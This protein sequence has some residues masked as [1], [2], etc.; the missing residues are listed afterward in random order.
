MI[1]RAETPVD[2]DAAHAVERLAFGSPLE[3][4]IVRAVRG[5]K[6][7]FGFV[8]EDEKGAV[9]GHVQC[10]RVWVG[11][12]QVTALGPIGVLPDRQGR[13]IGRSLVEAAVAEASAGG[14]L[15]VVLLGD[16]ALYSRFGFRPAAE[17]GLQNPFTGITEDGFT[18][19]EEDFMLLPLD[20]RVES[21]HGDVRWHPAFGQ[22]G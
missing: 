12:A 8:A 22:A 11:E 5:E 1:I 19:A 4:D 13:G 18:I 10:S 6:G 17:F 14:E 3:A 2:A 16:P 7:S 15:A 9:V 20:D 21:L